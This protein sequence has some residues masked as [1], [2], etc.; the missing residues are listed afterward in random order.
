MD[1]N[2]AETRREIIDKNLRI[3]GWEINDPS[4]VSIEFD[5]YLGEGTVEK[6]FR[7]EFTDHQFVDYLLL[8]KDGKHLAVVR[9][10]EPPK[11]LRLAR[12]KLYNMPK[13]LKRSLAWT[14]LLCFIQTV[15]KLFSG[16]LKITHQEGYS[17]FPHEMI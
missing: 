17:V 5:I 10:K 8:G 13:T 16:T 3:A 12:N 4:Q 11:T 1:K 7:T 6:E 2:E 14:G 9:Q 15:M